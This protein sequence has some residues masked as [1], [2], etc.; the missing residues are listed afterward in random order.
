MLDPPALR[1]VSR[2]S[3][4]VTVE[5]PSTQRVEV[6]GVPFTVRMPSTDVRNTL[7]KC[8][9]IPG[10]D[11]DDVAAGRDSDLPYPIRVLGFLQMSERVVALIG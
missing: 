11:A 10:D 8:S 4:T 3:V 2:P 7:S 1:T 6:V 9:G 5:V